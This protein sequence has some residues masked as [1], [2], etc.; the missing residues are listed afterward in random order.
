MDCG[1]YQD[2]HG[3]QLIFLF[4]LYTK[5]LLSSIGNASKVIFNYPSTTNRRVNS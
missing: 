2:Y 5:K 4:F 1:I 3:C